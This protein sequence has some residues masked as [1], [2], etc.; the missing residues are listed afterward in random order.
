[1]GLQKNA[2]DWRAGVKPSVGLMRCAGG[3]ATTRCRVERRTS[4]D[5]RARRSPAFTTMVLGWMVERRCQEKQRA[6]R[7]CH[8]YDGR[9]GLI[10]FGV[11]VLHLKTTNRVLEQESEGTIICMRVSSRIFARYHV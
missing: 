5:Q 4:L 1:M 6:G 9:S 7:I 11:R 10:L 2:I 8:T 3:G